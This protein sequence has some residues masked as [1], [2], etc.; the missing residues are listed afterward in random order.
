MRVFV[1]VCMYASVFACEYECVF[2]CMCAHV[3]VPHIPTHVSSESLGPGFISSEH[4][5]SSPSSAKQ[6]EADSPALGKDW[7]RGWGRGWGA[8]GTQRRLQAGVQV[9][10]GAGGAPGVWEAGGG[11]AEEGAG[12]R[13]ISHS[14]SPVGALVGQTEAGA[15]KGVGEGKGRGQILQPGSR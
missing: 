12:V 9:V 8:G 7:K 3:C 5:G 11:V 2:V 15:S 1:C 4:H 14:L 13:L 6:R 10:P